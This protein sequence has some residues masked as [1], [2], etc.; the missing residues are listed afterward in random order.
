MRTAASFASLSRTGDAMPLAGVSRYKT[1]AIHPN[2]ADVGGAISLLK[3]EGFTNG[4]ISLL[5]REQEH[6]QEK[7]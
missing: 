2:F 6:W 1:I 7:L 3:K 5:G 4:Q